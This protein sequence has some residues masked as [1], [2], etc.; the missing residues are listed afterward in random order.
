MRTP[1]LAAL[2]LASPALAQTWIVDASGNGDFTTLQA[3]IDQAS[4]GDVL[5]IEP[6]AQS[7]DEA[8]LSKSL[9]LVGRTS[10]GQQ[11]RIESLDVQ[12]TSS[13]TLFG[14]EFDKLRLKDLS[15]LALVDSCVF[16]SAQG[17][18]N[19]GWPAGPATFG[20]FIASPL[21]IEDCADARVVHSESYPGET[22][23]LGFAA[24][25]VRGASQA[26]F[27]S[28]RLIGKDV[29]TD[30]GLEGWGGDAL[31]VGDSSHV[32]VA[33]SQLI[34]GHGE[35]DVLDGW[36][37]KHY[38]LGGNALLLR[39]AATAEV[40]GNSSHRLR[41]GLGNGLGDP[42]FGLSNPGD[43]DAVACALDSTG[44][45]DLYGPTIEGELGSCATLH[46]TARPFLS[47]ADTSQALGPIVA[48]GGT[49]SASVHAS[50]ASTAVLLG[51]LSAAALELSLVETTAV[52]VDLGS[53]LQITSGV[54]TGPTSTL[55]V[56]WTLPAS[57]QFA[58]LSYHVQGF[59]LAPSLQLLGTN[60]GAITF[61]N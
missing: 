53:L 19:V 17:D 50:P 31:D 15:G 39:G 61:A 48:P 34:G 47:L 32:L 59:E 1:L 29:D 12:L 54:P 35:N 52:W 7:Y 60:A 11:P 26:Q 25:I 8:Q 10:G 6:A 56:Q 14:L 9:T 57:P 36:Y 24:A 23:A 43:G 45:A 42:F 16:G 3:A 38:G 4:E 21:L 58:G 46:P 27:T 44:Q 37:I 30:M 33:D 49:R 18:S 55:D 2:V 40:R 41:E 20:D 13:V 28:C 5:L 22:F 51:S